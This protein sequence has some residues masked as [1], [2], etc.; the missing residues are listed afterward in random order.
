MLVMVFLLC[1][2]NLEKDMGT[3]FT[4][5]LSETTIPSN[6]EDSSVYVVQRNEF[7]ENGRILKEIYFD[8]DTDR[9]VREVERI[10]YDYD[11]EGNLIE[12][13]TFWDSS[14]ESIT[15]KSFEYDDHNRLLTVYSYDNLSERY[16]Y[17]GQGNL[18]NKYCYDSRGNLTD[19][20][21]YVY[22]NSLLS[23]TTYMYSDDESFE[24]SEGNYHKV[25]QKNY[26]NE[27]Y[28]DSGRLSKVTSFYHNEEP[29]YELYTY[30]DHQ[31]IIQDYSF[32]GTAGV[33]TVLDYDDQNRKIRHTVFKPDGKVWFLNVYEYT[34]FSCKNSSYS[35][36]GKLEYS[37]ISEWNEQNRQVFEA[38]YDAEGKLKASWEYIYDEYGYIS[39]I[40]NTDQD[41][42]VKTE[43]APHRDFYSNGSV[44]AEIFYSDEDYIA[45]AYRK[46]Y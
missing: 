40:I 43:I 30:N 11:I 37:S 20:E 16:I 24:D 41:G 12:E 35:T 36:D 25:I 42:N 45:P 4:T 46:R 14:S 39:S 7:D 10:E 28:D 29:Y 18:T 19:Y 33:R 2:C 31:T 26:V 8:I 5:A 22:N 27:E 44:K 21:E 9:K 17:D 6:T 38:S 15:E 3:E 34:E 1:G 32:D 13:K 23:R